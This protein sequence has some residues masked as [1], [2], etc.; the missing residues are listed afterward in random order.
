MPDSERTLSTAGRADFE[1]QIARL[2]VMGFGCEHL[3]SSPWKRAQETARLLAAAIGAEVK[4][5][6]GL[7]CAPD[8]ATGRELIAQAAR[9]ARTAR[10]VL[11]GHQ[12]WLGEL[13]QGLGAAG[14]S[15][16]DCGEVLWLA[17]GPARSWSV[18]AR[19]FP[20]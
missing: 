2:K 8:S 11:V 12:P 18:A 20:G 14:V 7:C 16:L 4:T 3:W 1:R 5:R 10:V 13:A 15:G 9:L 19:L 17:P 6:E